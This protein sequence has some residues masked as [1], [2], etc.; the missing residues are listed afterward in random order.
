M[1]P[2]ATK[3]MIRFESGEE[4]KAFQKYIIPMHIR[5]KEAK[6]KVH[7]IAADIPLLISRSTTESIA[8]A[9]NIVKSDAVTRTK[10]ADRGRSTW[11]GEKTE[12]VRTKWMSEIDEDGNWKTETILTICQGAGEE[13][14][15]IEAKLEARKRTGKRDN[16]ESENSRISTARTEVAIVKMTGDTD[17]IEIIPAHMKIW[18]I[19]GHPERRLIIKSTMDI[20]K[21][22]NAEADADEKAKRLYRKMRDTMRE[23]GFGGTGRQR[24]FD[25]SH[26]STM[27]STLEECGDSTPGTANLNNETETSR[28]R[29]TKSETEQRRKGQMEPSDGQKKWSGEKKH[30]IGLAEMTRETSQYDT[31]EHGKTK[32]KNGV[33]QAIRGKEGKTGQK[34]EATDPSTFKRMTFNRSTPQGTTLLDRDDDDQEPSDGHGKTQH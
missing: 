33:D 13:Q 10:Q 34:R 4:H 27:E 23:L 19:R 24:P 2:F 12:T 1:G 31:N 16:G 8:A 28:E 14:T 20:K 11:S 30:S 7:I 6:V 18:I 29:T 3:T 17:E 15:R 5:G 9:E 21:R 22:K 26:E 25:K 32:P